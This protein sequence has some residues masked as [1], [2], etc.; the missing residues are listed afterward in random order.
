MIKT[1]CASDF[2][3]KKVGYVK[4]PI[5]GTLI[6]IT[7]GR[8]YP[9]L[10]YN[11]WKQVLSPSRETK[12][13]WLK[14]KRTESDW[15]SYEEEFIPQMKKREAIKAIKGLSLRATKGETITLLC[16]CKEGQHCH[17]YIV[18]SL[19]EKYQRN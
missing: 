7:R 11:E 13:R 10:D 2:N 17:R 4:P 18:K 14:S 9:W 8:P 16:Y 3:K 12:D 6:L 15:K 1:A 5:N 19:I